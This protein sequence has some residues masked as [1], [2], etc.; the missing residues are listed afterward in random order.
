MDSGS[1][2]DIGGI[3]WFE[4]YCKNQNI[5]MEKLKKEISNEAF[6]F[7]VGKV[8][9]TLYVV[10]LPFNFKDVEGEVITVMVKVNVLEAKIPLLVGRHFHRKYE[11]Y[12]GMNASDSK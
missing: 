11:E 2:K 5:D 7:G 3:D 12:Q 10:E 9:P 8:W 4:E 6:R 1:P